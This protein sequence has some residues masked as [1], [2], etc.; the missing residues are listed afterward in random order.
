MSWTAPYGVWSSSPC[1]VSFRTASDT[2][3]SFSPVF[4]AIDV[5]ET[6][7]SDHSERLQTAF[8]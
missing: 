4:S 7:P 1:A 5:G 3:E 8:R 6:G 2:D